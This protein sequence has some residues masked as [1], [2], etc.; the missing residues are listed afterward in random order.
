MIAFIH[1]I[2]LYYLIIV[3]YLDLGNYL[4]RFNKKGADK[5]EEAFFYSINLVFI[6]Q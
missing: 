2:D 5:N 6:A 3:N 4:G 1:K